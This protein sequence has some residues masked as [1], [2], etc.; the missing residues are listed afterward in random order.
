MDRETSREQ[1]NL[2]H[3]VE[4]LDIPYYDSVPIEVCLFNTIRPPCPIT[5]HP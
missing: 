5:Q 3:R 1:D 4:Q 2:R